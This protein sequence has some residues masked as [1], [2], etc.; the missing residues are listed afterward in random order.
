M[1]SAFSSIWSSVMPM[2][3][4][5]LS[6][7]CHEG[8]LVSIADD[9]VGEATAGGGI[10]DCGCWWLDWCL[11]PKMPPSRPW[12]FCGPAFAAAAWVPKGLLRV[13]LW[14]F[15]SRSSIFFLKVRAS[16]SSAKE[17]AARQPSISK[18]WKKTRSWL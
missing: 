16:F 7:G 3:S 6:S 15:F 1:K 5:S 14:A 10:M 12:D 2:V 4:S 8:S 18:V 11:W 13:F 9:F 17:R